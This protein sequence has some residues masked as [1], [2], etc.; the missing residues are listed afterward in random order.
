MDEGLLQTF[1]SL[2]DEVRTGFREMK[3]ASGELRVVHG[4]LESKDTV[5]AYRS[6]CLPVR[7]AYHDSDR[8]S[9]K[10]ARAELKQSSRPGVSA[11]VSSAATRY[12]KIL[13]Y[14]HSSTT[15][16]DRQIPHRDIFEAWLDA[17]IFGDFGGK[18][19]RYRELLSECGKAIEGIAVRLTEMIGNHVLELDDIVADVLDQERKS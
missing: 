7:R 12:Q 17:S 9:I 14:L 18:D 8:V 16:N 3:E 15:L 4:Y 10:H 11:R 5:G 19:K 1:R 6:L 13:D 2:A